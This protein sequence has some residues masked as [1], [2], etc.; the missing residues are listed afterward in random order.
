MSERDDR[1]TGVEADRIVRD[2]ERDSQNLFASTLHK[3]AQKSG[4]SAGKS[5]APEDPAEKWGRIVGRT[6]GF[7]FLILLVVNL[8]TGKI[9]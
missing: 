7:G 2:A 4:L 8:F 1:K 3:L 6:L 5:G 9:F